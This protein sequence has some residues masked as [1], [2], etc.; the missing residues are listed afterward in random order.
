MDSGSCTYLAV[1]NVGTLLCRL[2]LNSLNII[3]MSW[4]TPTRNPQ[5]VNPLLENG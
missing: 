4:R 2:S 5:K 3:I 1:G